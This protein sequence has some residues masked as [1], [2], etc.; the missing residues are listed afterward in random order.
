MAFYNSNDYYYNIIRKNIKK[1][2]KKKKYTQQ[3]LAEDTDLS[4]D[5][6]CE[7][8][9]LTKN[10]SFSIVTLGRIAD[11]LEVDI[12]DFFSKE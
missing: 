7:I 9:S 4:V 11:V 1:Y 2:R 5:Y 10:K 12:R 6:V 8:E 3:K